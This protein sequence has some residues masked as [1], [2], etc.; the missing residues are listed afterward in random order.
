[1]DTFDGNPVNL[2]PLSDQEWA[3]KLMNLISEDTLR[4]EIPRAIS[5]QEYQYA[6]QLC[7]LFDNTKTIDDTIISWEID[8]LLA[9]SKQE[10]SACGRN[11]Y[12]ACAN[13]L[14]NQSK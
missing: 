2:H 9:L 10:T 6:L 5:Q 4:N 13:D 12:I 8:C 7:A 11:Y 1:M 14:K 3:S